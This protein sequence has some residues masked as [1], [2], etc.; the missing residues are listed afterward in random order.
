[1]FAIGGQVGSHTEALAS[2]CLDG[3][4]KIYMGKHDRSFSAMLFIRQSVLVSCIKHYIAE[5]SSGSDGSDLIAAKS[6]QGLCRCMLGPMYWGV[7]AALF[8]P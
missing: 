3:G 8:T 4:N 2:I 7:L 1:M 5:Q 6:T